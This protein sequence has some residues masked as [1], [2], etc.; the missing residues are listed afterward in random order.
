VVSSNIIIL[1]PIADLG[2]GK[3]YR[4]YVGTGVKSATG[5]SLSTYDSWIFTT[6]S[7]Y[8]VNDGSLVGDQWCTA[9]GNDVNDGLTPATPKRT[10]SALLAAY[11]ILPGRT[12]YVDTGTYT[13]TVAPGADDQGSALGFVSFLGSTNGSVIQASAGYAFDLTGLGYI[14]IENFIIRGVTS[15][16]FMTGGNNRIYRNVIKKHS[17]DGIV[18]QGSPNTVIY[19]NTI[20]SNGQYGINLTLD[21]SDGLVISRNTVFYN[22]DGGVWADNADSCRFDQNMLYRNDSNVTKWGA[23]AFNG[24]ATQ[25]DWTIVNNTFFSNYSRGINIAGGMTT[26]EIQDNIGAF[27]MD[28]RAAWNLGGRTYSYSLRWMSDETGDTGDTWVMGAGVITNLD[29]LFKSFFSDFHLQ[30]NSPAIGTGSG[31]QCMGRYS[32]RVTPAS[33][34]ANTL[35]THTIRFATTYAGSIPADGEIWIQYP[36]GFRFSPGLTASSP[37]LGGSLT[38][39]I[40][41]TGLVR[42]L[43]TGGSAS[44]AGNPETIVLTGVTNATVGSVNN[45]IRWWTKRNDASFV[46]YPDD[47]NDFAITSS[48]GPVLRNGVAYSATTLKGKASPKVP[49]STVT[50]SMSF[51]NIGGTANW[52][53]FRVPIPSNCQFKTN[54]LQ[55]VTGWTCQYSTNNTPVQTY[56][57][58]SYSLT[59]VKYPVSRIKWVRWRSPSMGAGTVINVQ[60]QVIIR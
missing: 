55:S 41:G 39:V 17:A 18:A 43:R 1:N 21:T 20:C 51:S 6:K 19:G 45:K 33:T 4:V 12:V 13:E 57:S 8:F 10:V 11:S 42:I 54:S 46:D 26:Y 58:T 16:I 38:P 15:G 23:L 2:T 29:P 7:H 49:G 50:C 5:K 27:C 36:S 3:S 56:L 25:D 40:A 44:T 37:S 48:G 31:G 35:T 22:A 53:V 24:G 9:V 60:F 52:P 30:Y 28:N 59:N 14:S 34:A 32:A 47:S